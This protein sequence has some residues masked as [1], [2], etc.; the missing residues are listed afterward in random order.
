MCGWGKASKRC[1]QCKIAI[2]CQSQDRKSASVCQ[3]AIRRIGNKLRRPA[4]KNGGGP[5]VRGATTVEGE[6]CR[7]SKR[8]ERDRGMTKEGPLPQVPV[9]RGDQLVHAVRP[10]RARLVR[11]DRRGI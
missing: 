2:D 3:L 10:P 1:G 5:A 4:R 7:G 9:V 11:L 6:A 8:D